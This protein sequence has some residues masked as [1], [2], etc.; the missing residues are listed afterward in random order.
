MRW[1]SLLLALPAFGADDPVFLEKGGVVMIEAESTASRLGKWELKTS[2]AGF[3]GEGHLE[4][5]GNKP[6]TGPA[7]SPLKYRF[8][9]SKPGNYSLILRGHKR[10]ISKREDICNDCY[11]A[12]DGDFDSGSKT[13]KSILT[14]DTKMFGGSAD[15]W[16]WCVKL[17]ANHKKWDP[18]YTLKEGETYELTISGRSQNFN[19]D[20]IILLHESE[21]LN[22]VKKKLPKESERSGGKL[23]STDRPQPVSRTLTHKDGRQIKATLLSRAGDKVT[24]RVDGRSMTIPLDILSED[25]RKFIGEWSPE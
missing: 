12:L 24:A 3:S 25:D 2:V 8:E 18:I 6:E 15:G 16:G 17:D 13:P 23:S 19:L 14:S 9:V 11:V 20:A 7:N 1:I 22:S 10:L 21:S 4:F 5:T